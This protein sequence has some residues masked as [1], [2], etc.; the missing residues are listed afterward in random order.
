MGSVLADYRVTP[1]HG[2]AEQAPLESSQ[3][4]L[5]TR[6][7]ARPAAIIACLR[8]HCARDVS[9]TFPLL[10]LSYLLSKGR[11][12][13][14]NVMQAILAGREGYCVTFLVVPF[15]LAHTQTIETP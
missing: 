8:G 14:R 5:Q 10:N 4:Y 13:E 11:L 2:M 15:R 7:P 3:V 1:Y 9:M 6:K 12:E